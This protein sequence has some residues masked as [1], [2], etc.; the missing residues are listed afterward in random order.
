MTPR[1]PAISAAK[2][3]KVLRSHDF[4]VARQSGSHVVLRHPDGRRVTVPVYHSRD[5]GRGLLRRVMKDAGLTRDDV[6][7]G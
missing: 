4:E 3:L 7:A 2:L 1:L 5:L 6:I